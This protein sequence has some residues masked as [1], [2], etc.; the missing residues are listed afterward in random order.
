MW[1]L[2]RD[3]RGGLH[4]RKGLRMVR[5]T[6]TRFDLFVLGMLQGNKAELTPYFTNTGVRHLAFELALPVAVQGFNTAYSNYSKYL[7]EHKSIP[8]RYCSQ[9]TGDRRICEAQRLKNSHDS[10]G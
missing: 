1:H 6:H 4:I 2:A 10:C 9:S 7:R 8:F 3:I 5:L